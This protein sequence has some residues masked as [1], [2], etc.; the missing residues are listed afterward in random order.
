M[1]YCFKQGHFFFRSFFSRAYVAVKRVVADGSEC[2]EYETLASTREVATELA[3]RRERM[4][5]DI[6][7]TD[8]IVEVEIREVEE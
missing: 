1:L 3:R 2:F 5:A 6:A 8:R 4:W 7:A